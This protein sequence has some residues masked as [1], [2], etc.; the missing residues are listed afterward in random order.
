MRPVDSW[1]DWQIA[2]AITGTLRVFYSL[3]AAVLSFLL[4]PDAALI[5]SNQLT[6]NLGTAGNWHY[7]L[8][9]VWERFD[10]LWYLRIAARG[11]DLPMAVIFYPLYPA[12]IRIVG[13]VMPGTAAALV[14]ATVAV[15]FFLWGLLRLASVELSSVGRV[16][17]VLLVCVW[18][19][20]FILFAGYAD[21]LTLALVVWTV[22]LGREGRWWSATACAFL[23]GLS[24]PS[25]VLVALVLI[26]M[27]WRSQRA[28]SLVV[29]LAPIGTLG[30]WAWLHGTG[31][32][33][34]VS[35]YAKYQDMILAP[36]WASV[37]KTLQLIFGQY[38]LLLAIKFGLVIFVLVLGVERR[39]RVE[40]RLLVLAVV[41][42]ILMYTGA[43]PMAGAP[44][45]LMAAY[46]VFL[47]LGRRAE[48]WR[49]W[50]TCFYLCAF[51]FL[52]L[53]WMRSFLEWSL[54]F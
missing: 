18:P 43:R 53:M 35:A 22:V 27:A 13:M 28:K 52:N 1:K 10:T 2:L 12:T 32:L 38:D 7:A 21:A 19:T 29:L 30:Y 51:G 9:G 34:V 45:Y 41:L 15:F 20:S 44:R 48:R 25:G 46:P 33:S 50:Q 36:P 26:V 47:A 5:R 6:E 24:R 11:Y 49:T 4:H 54:S 3:L 39:L 8:L 42:Q 37:A 23:A 14:V 16:R 17:M 40:D 31:R